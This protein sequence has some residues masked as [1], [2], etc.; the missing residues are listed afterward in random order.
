MYTYSVSDIG[1]LTT[2]CNLTKEV[3]LEALER[4]GLLKKPAVEICSEYAVVLSQPNWLGRLFRKIA[5]EGEGHV[6]IRIMKA[7]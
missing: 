4:D 6:T 2:K 7:V 3:L 5:G 1:D